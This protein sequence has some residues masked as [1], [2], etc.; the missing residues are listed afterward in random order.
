M[1]SAEVEVPVQRTARLCYAVCR[2]LWAAPACSRA[3]VR[4]GH[5][6]DAPFRTEATDAFGIGQAIYHMQCCQLESIE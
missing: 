4:A 6:C 3:C 2:L 5:S 1:L